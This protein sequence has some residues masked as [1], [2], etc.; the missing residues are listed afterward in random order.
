MPTSKTNPACA[1]AAMVAIAC[2][3][4]AGAQSPP[5]L[6]NGELT[7]QVRVRDGAYEIF[8]SALPRPVLVAGIGAKVNQRWTFSSDY[9]RHRIVA[10]PFRD[11]LGA[12]RSLTIVYSGLANQ[13]EL[14]VRLRLYDRQPFGDLEV[15]VRNATA[16][17]IT[18]QA[19][20]LVAAAGPE[21]VS[22][23]GSENDNR[24]LAESVSEDPSINIGGLAQAPPGGYVGYRDTLIYNLASRQSL[25]LAALTEDRFLT[26]SHLAVGG[27]AG[28]DRI[29]AFTLDNT[30]ATRAMLDRTQISPSQRVLLSLPVAPGES[31]GSELVMFAAGPGFLPPLERYG[32]AVRQ[33]HHLDFSPRQ[34]PMGWWSWTAFYGGINA[35]E[36]LTNA[37][38][39]AQN[40]KS[41][42]Y[43]FFHLD[44]GYD[45]ARGE[46]AT[47]NAAQ[48]PNGM[49][50]LERRISRL[51]LTPGIWTAPFEVSE[52]AWVYQHH[53][54]WLLHD[55]QGKPIMIGYV[56][57][58]A[59]RLFVLDATNPGAQ[60]Y[61]RQTYRTLTH[62]WGV[63]YIKLDFMDASAIEG[64]YYR[65]HTTALEAQRIGLAIIRQAVG[66][67]VLLDK[68]GSAMLAPVGFVDEGR[69]A[70]DTGH[71]FAAS[72]D[73]VTNIASR[74]YMDGNFYVADPDAFSVSRQ[75]EPQQHWHQSQAGLTPREAQ[76][77]IVLA[78]LAGGMFEIGDDLPTLGADPAAMALVKN[79]QIIAMNRLGYAALPLDL[80]TFRPADEAPSVFFVREDSRQAMLAIFNWSDRPTSHV[81][82]MAQ[83]AEERM[84]A[85]A[86]ASL[87]AYDVLDH[88]APITTDGRLIRIAKQEP[89]SVRLIKLVDGSMP[90]RPPVITA[91]VP[92][93]A[94]AGQPVALAAAA[95]DGAV[96]AL[97]FR[98]DF[99]DGTDAQ[100]RQ[101][102][103][104]FTHAGNFTVQLTVSGIEGV[105]ARQR[106]SVAVAG[107]PQT[108]F[109]LQKNRRFQPH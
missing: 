74:F 105:S 65:P 62:Q 24:V 22:L 31:L 78:A 47:A 40:L 10:Q 61:L 49:G 20:R 54:G 35:G 34:A 21:F 3:A 50:M 93:N 7:V 32:A 16:R 82:D 6:A 4:I 25:L 79:P 100:G 46:Y 96:P 36:A 86:H 83:L 29:T 102:S 66:P 72:K 26:V 108:Q 90:P 53:P 84:G 1:V 77:Q 76:L 48:F 58:R 89:R 37:Q 19:I 43:D 13:P 12:G 70:P 56:H 28:G 45:Y 8:T 92:A 73:A 91:R 9:P 57:D 52:R 11:V 2:C 101:V 71:S 98:W 27:A 59:D 33:L 104:T 51:G 81:M 85:P 55:Y 88:D 18:V 23:G 109:T 103:H 44:E 15:R 14:I 67:D 97:D 38:W 39:L 75:I 63:R 64:N 107:Y 42:G 106:F 41:L 60:A 68:D 95:A 69:I 30:G 94:A 80:M 5:R 87:R 17:P 99:G